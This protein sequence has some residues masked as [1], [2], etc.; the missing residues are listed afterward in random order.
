LLIKESDYGVG[1]SMLAI[2][3]VVERAFSIRRHNVTSRKNPSQN[4]KD[5]EAKSARYSALA[6]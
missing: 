5:S 6:R 1:C 4:T 3:Y 2:A